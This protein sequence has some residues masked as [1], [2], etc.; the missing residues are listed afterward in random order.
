MRKEIKK[1]EVDFTEV[2]NHLKSLITLEKVSRASNLLQSN[3]RVSSK[4]E[5]ILLLFNYCGIVENVDI[6]ENLSE[7][8]MHNK[9]QSFTLTTRLA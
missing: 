5:T 7:N 8:P 1:D 3:V 4:N 9:I 2:K 6:S